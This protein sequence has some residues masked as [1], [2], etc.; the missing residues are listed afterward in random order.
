MPVSLIYTMWNSLSDK[1]K[2][3]IITTY[4]NGTESL[5]KSD[6]TLAKAI[7]SALAMGGTAAKQID[8]FIKAEKI[9]MRD[10][11]YLSNKYQPK[12]VYGSDGKYYSL[13]KF[14]NGDYTVG[15]TALAGSTNTAGKS[16]DD[17]AIWRADNGDL[18]VWVGNGGT[19][20]YYAQV[21]ADNKVSAKLNAINFKKVDNSMN[22]S[23]LPKSSL[24]DT[25]IDGQASGQWALGLDSLIGSNKKQTQGSG[26]I[27]SPST[28]AAYS[29][30]GKQGLSEAEVTKLIEELTKPKVYSADEAA[31]ILGID[32]NEQ[33]ILN[34]YN[35]KTNTFYD[36]AVGLQ[37]QLRNDVIK[38]NAN[39][40]Q[41]ITDAYIDSNKYTAPTATNRA[42]QAANLMNTNM[43]AATTNSANDYGFQQTMQNLEAS[44]RAELEKNPQLARE[45]YNQIGTALSGWSADQNASATKQY[46]D[47]LDAYSQMYAA[48]RATQADMAYANAAKYSGLANAA[49][50]NAQAAAYRAQSKQG[51]F[52]TMYDFYY[53]LYN[54]NSKHAYSQVA[55]LLSNSAGDITNK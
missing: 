23:K 6:S 21:G 7:G 55:S 48:N 19:G 49:M 25:A 27:G 47:S 22:T 29:G 31:K 24:I 42:I 39:Y 1:Q 9:R 14:N 10:A 8:S 3:Q 11:Q 16:M 20:G 15:D 43:S 40:L 28:G 52:N 5:K 26:N 46:V 41:S 4:N 34:D 37:D 45:Y 2:Q 12:G 38:N 50:N 35:E 30:G 53:N 44:R 54:Q 32:Y 33:N 36:E 18:Y 13:S 17:Q 51:A